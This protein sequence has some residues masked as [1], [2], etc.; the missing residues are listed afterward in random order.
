MMFVKSPLEQF[1]VFEIFSTLSSLIYAVTGISI[2]NVTLFIGVVFGIFFFFF[3]L[4]GIKI[5][6]VP[7]RVQILIET[8]TTFISTLVRDNVGVKYLNSIFYIIWFL[9]LLIFGL[10][11]TGMIPFSFTV[12]SHFIITFAMSLILFIAVNVIGILKHGFHIYKL[13]LPEGAPKIMLP[14][15]FVIELIS[16]TSRIFSLSIRLF[17]NLMSGHTLLKILAGFAWIMFFL[18]G[19]PAIVTGIPMLIIILVTGLELAIAA[20]QAYVFCML[21]CLYYNDVIHL[22]S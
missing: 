17:A 16:Y 18:G 7:K 5:T 15:L 2:D 19:V 11:L 14:L 10:N 4:V 1:E 12:T 6:L 3:K 8:S 13:F 22:H 20:L 9:F 21:L